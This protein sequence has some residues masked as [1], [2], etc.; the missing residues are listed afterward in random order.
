M[1]NENVTKL[2]LLK[3]QC[4]RTSRII[5]RL[6]AILRM[7]AVGQFL[8]KYALALFLFSPAMSWAGAP[9]ADDKPKQGASPST[10]RQE[11]YPGVVVNQTVTVAGQDFYQR[12]VAAWRERDLS[13]RFSISIH[14]RPSP[15]W[16][17]QIWIEFAQRRIFQSAL[18]G[19]RG[20]IQALAEKAIETAYQL[21]ADAE[22]DR[23]LFR[24]ADVGPDEI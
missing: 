21:V 17:S 14:E 9:E 20:E 23:L 7:L 18:P 3:M 10:L 12:F 15:R 4:C 11:A 24:D 6:G 19:G 8:K 2:T 1:C 22:V 16:G 5:S 13:E